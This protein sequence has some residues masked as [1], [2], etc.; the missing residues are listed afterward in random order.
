M[1]YRLKELSK[2]IDQLKIKLNK[3]WDEKGN[4][5]EEI[6]RVSEEIDCLLNEHDRLLQ[7]DIKVS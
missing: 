5:N 6:L 1:S 7:H 2:Q 3:L 4:T